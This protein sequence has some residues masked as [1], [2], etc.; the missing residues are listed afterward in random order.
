MNDKP[1]NDLN[2]VDKKYFIVGLVDTD[3]LLHENHD[4]R[5]LPCII[6]SHTT[7]L[8]L[9]CVNYNLWKL[10]FKLF[11]EESKDIEEF[12]APTLGWTI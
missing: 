7:H 3:P 4:V 8:C 6:P 11:L 5:I 2:N 10:S 12:F 9:S 1:K